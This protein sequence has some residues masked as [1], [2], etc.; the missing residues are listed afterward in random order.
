MKLPAVIVT[1]PSC[2]QLDEFDTV[3]TKLVELIAPGIPDRS[4]T[5]SGLPCSEYTDSF[6]AVHPPGTHVRTAVLSL[7]DPTAVFNG[8]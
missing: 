5:V 3:H 4:V 2:V 1:L 7:L 6:V 8:K